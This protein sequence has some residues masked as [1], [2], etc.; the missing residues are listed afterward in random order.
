MPALCCNIYSGMKRLRKPNK[1]KC[2]KTNKIV[3]HIKACNNNNG[4][5]ECSIK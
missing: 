4:L 3:S 5:A 1:L 2:N